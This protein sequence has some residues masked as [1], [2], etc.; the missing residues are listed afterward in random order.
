MLEMPKLIKEWKRVGLSVQPHDILLAYVILT[1][2]QTGKRN[3]TK[4]PK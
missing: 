2:Q 4:F 3:W 1:D